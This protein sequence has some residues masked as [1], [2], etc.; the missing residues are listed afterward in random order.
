MKWLDRSVGKSA[1]ASEGEGRGLVLSPGSVEPRRETG[2]A[3]M[4]H[5]SRGSKH[6]L[7]DVDVGEGG[8]RPV[9]APR[10]TRGVSWEAFKQRITL[11]QSITIQK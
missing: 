11:K 4:G 3:A 7:Y 1:S 5:P 2:P 10:M 9:G 6:G 8:R